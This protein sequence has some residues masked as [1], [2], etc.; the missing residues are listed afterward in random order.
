MNKHPKLLHSKL[1]VELAFVWPTVRAVIEYIYTTVVPIDA[2]KNIEINWHK[3]WLPKC[4]GKPCAHLRG[5]KT[6]RMNTLKGIKWNYRSYQNEFT[7]QPRMHVILKSHFAGCLSWFQFSVVYFVIYINTHPL[8]T[9]LFW[10]PFYFPILLACN[11]LM[12]INIIKYLTH[13]FS[14]LQEFE[15]R[16]AICAYTV[17]KYSYI[18]LL[19]TTYYL[20]ILKISVQKS[21]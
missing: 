4:F 5:D 3:Q 12:C 14:L 17:P 21:S 10:L 19:V 9:Y 7:S 20:S 18:F 1:N 2:H 11:N 6:Q 15:L 13:I 8:F 16:R